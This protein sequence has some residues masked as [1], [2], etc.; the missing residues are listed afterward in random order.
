MPNWISKL[1]T[2][3]HSEIYVNP[4]LLQLIPT[5]GSSVARYSPLKMLFLFWCPN[6]F[7]L[8]FIFN[9]KYLSCNS[10]K[11]IW[12]IFILL[13]L[14]NKW[15]SNPYPRPLTSY[16]YIFKSIK[17]NYSNFVNLVKYVFQWIIFL[18]DI[19]SWF[20]WSL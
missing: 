2:F 14:F 6:S 1:T 10:Y 12:P 8:S 5:E 17:T 11:N 4:G 18:F 20:L 3:Y 9:G 13:F 15:S 19:F 7:S 16:L